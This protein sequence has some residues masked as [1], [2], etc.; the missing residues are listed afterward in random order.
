MKYMKKITVGL[1]ALMVGMTLTGCGEGNVG[2]SSGKTKLTFQIWDIG[3]KAGME[4]MAA[5]YTEKNPNVEIEVQ[6]TNWSEYWTK[7]E[8]AAS[9]N[10]MPDVLWMHTNEILKYADNGM[11]ADLTE[12]YKD[13]SSSYYEEHFSEEI[14]GNIVGSDGK[15]YG[16]PKD[17]D[18]VCLVYN[19]EMFDQAGVTY[20]DEDWTWDDLVKASE[21]IYEKTGKYGY[22]AYADEQ[23]GYWPFVYQAGGYILNEDKTQAGFTDEATKKGMEFYI[24]LQ[25][26]E[27]CPDQ[28]FFAETAPG[29]AFFS[30]VGA[31]FI[32]GSWNLKASLDNYPEMIGKWDVAVLPKCPDPIRGDGRASIT[33]GLSYA[34]PAKGKNLEVA[35]DFIKFLGSEEGQRI[36][37]ESGAAIPAYNGLEQ[38]WVNIFDN[39]D[40][41]IDVQKCIDMFEYSIQSVNNAS[42]PEWKSKVNDAILKIYS[43]E[44]TLDQGL[45]NMQDI[46]DTASSK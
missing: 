29:T 40:Y 4:A 36:Q 32:E 18:T 9:G 15:I 43:G 27:W 25:K 30:E 46:V 21:E 41:K 39:Y 5:A 44:M 28:N 14:L 33:N 42:R 16:V 11:L 2:T 8:A 13:E 31:M 20:P 6:V 3:Q 7:M 23:L 17:K 19:K 35:K 37:G 10:S 45:Q 12:L 22:M 26:E 34:T 1:L 24:N 38:T